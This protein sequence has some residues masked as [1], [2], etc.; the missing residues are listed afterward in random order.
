MISVGLPG[1]D[2]GEEMRGKSPASRTPDRGDR[3]IYLALAT[4][5]SSLAH[6]PHEG[7]IEGVEKEHHVS[8]GEK[9]VRRPKGDGRNETDAAGGRVRPP[10][11]GAMLAGAAAHFPWYLDRVTLMNS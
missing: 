6:S 9:K 11:V 1:T 10:K 8:S 2:K 4:H 3:F 7:E 5:Q